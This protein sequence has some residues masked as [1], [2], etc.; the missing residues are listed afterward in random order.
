[1]KQLQAA[2]AIFLS[3]ITT[4]AWA[5]DVGSTS[6]RV[7]DGPTSPADAILG[8][9][10]SPDRESVVTVTK[11]D[12]GYMGVVVSAKS[13]ALVGKLMFRGL[14]YDAA[15]RTWTG[16]VF[17]PKR[18]EFVPATFSAKADGSLSMTAGKGLFSKTIL[19]TRA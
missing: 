2:L 6:E 4:T 17:A 16:E 12:H 9:W 3:L 7:A 14:M 10:A 8:A 18:G 1:M 5:R 13:S 15:H 11:T 19:W